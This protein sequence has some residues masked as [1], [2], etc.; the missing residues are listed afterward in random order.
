MTPTQ[1]HVGSTYAAR[2]GSSNG[3]IRKAVYVGVETTTKCVQTAFGQKTATRKSPVFAY[4]VEGE[5][6]VL[7]TEARWTIPWTEYEQLLDQIELVRRENESRK[8]IADARIQAVLDALGVT[9]HI[10]N[11]R[12]HYSSP[13]R[14]PFINLHSQRESDDC[15]RDVFTYYPDLSTI[16]LTLGQLESLTATRKSG[17]LRSGKARPAFKEQS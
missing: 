9:E 15:G 5:W 10:L 2:Q 14:F 7:D 3:A 8:R 12:K 4:E 1:L 6:K 13:E 11:R 17:K 16:T